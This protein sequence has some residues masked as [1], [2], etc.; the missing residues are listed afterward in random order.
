M[1]KKLPV[2]LIT[3]VGPGTGSAMV[4]RFARGGYAVA[5]L[6]RTSERLVCLEKEI[7]PVRGYPYD[8]TDEA[9][10]DAAI[11]KVRADLGPTLADGA[12]AAAPLYAACHQT[13]REQTVPVQ[14]ALETTAAP[15]QLGE[16][17]FEKV[18]ASRS[19]SSSRRTST[20]RSS[21]S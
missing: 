18:L 12:A 15:P 6:A 19:A 14:R 16:M 5:M 4:R 11:A 17:L 7:E 3:G 21:S 20:T 8:V 2:A 1:E 13:A 10:L 9:Q